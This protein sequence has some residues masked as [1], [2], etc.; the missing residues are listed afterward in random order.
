MPVREMSS[1]TQVRHVATQAIA[2]NQAAAAFGAVIDTVDHNNGVGFYVGATAFTDGVYTL[3][4]EEADD[5]GFT[6]NVA[7]LDRNHIVG[8]PALPVQI[9]ALNAAGVDNYQRLGVISTRQFV[10]LLVEAT[11][12]TAGATL[13]A[14]AVMHPDIVP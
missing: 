11:G 3:T 14:L 10:R 4:V 1:R 6:Q 13:N 8:Q 12:V 7:V 2:A 9:T 5:A